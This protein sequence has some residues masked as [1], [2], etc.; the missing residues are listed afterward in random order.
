ML[1]L[2]SIA[3]RR[4]VC[5]WT[6]KICRARRQARDRRSGVM[7]APPTATPRMQTLEEAVEANIVQVTS[8]S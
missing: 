2:V 5:V 7:L 1:Q 8:L 3:A 4:V 6:C